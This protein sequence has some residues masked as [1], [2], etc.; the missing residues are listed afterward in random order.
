MEEP[1]KDKEGGENEP[2]PAGD[3]AGS[4]VESSKHDTISDLLLSSG[5]PTP[6]S[7]STDSNQG[8]GQK[9]ETEG[10]GREEPA[11]A[12][13]T[14]DAEEHQRSNKRLRKV[15]LQVLILEVRKEVYFHRCTP[16]R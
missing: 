6:R 16:D 11:K 15:H 9:R 13:K 5:Q 4:D 7:S 8:G 10:E 1:G 14:A 12:S 3:E 2:E